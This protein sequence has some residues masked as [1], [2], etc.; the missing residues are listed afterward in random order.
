[1]QPSLANCRFAI[2]SGDGMQCV[3]FPLHPFPALAGKG[4]GLLWASPTLSR[5]PPCTFPVRSKMPLFRQA[6]QGAALQTQFPRPRVNGEGG[7]RGKGH[8][9][10][11]FVRLLRGLPCLQGK[12]DRTAFREEH[13]KSLPIESGALRD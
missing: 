4:K 13:D 1:M 12:P 6:V 10:H 2:E 11:F 9:L 5:A 7:Y 8:A 3:P